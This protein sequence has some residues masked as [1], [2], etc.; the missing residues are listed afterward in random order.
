MELTAQQPQGGEAPELLPPPDVGA[1]GGLNLAYAVQWWLF[2]GIAVGGWV[3]L[4]RRE[5]RDLRT[6]EASQAVTVRT[7]M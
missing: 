6:Q 5:A 3:L 4:V 2:I 1:G 7:A